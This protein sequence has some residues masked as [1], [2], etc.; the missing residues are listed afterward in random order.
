MP[1]DPANRYFLRQWEKKAQE[2]L[3]GRKIQENRLEGK[4]QEDIRHK[5]ESKNGH[6]CREHPGKENQKDKEGLI[7]GHYKK[8]K[9]GKHTNQGRT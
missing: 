4:V 1:R 2:E 8:V 6:R 7:G 3:K 5:K 9:K